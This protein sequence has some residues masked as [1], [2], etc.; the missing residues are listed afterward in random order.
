MRAHIMR[1]FGMDVFQRRSS[2]KDLFARRLCTAACAVIIALCCGVSAAHA[3]DPG[4]DAAPDPP[5]VRVTGSATV[6]GDVYLFS[7]NPDSANRPR[8]PSN[9]WRLILSPTI[10]FGDWLT[11]PL[12]ITLASREVNVTTPV[13]GGS[14][15]IQFLQNPMNNLGFLSISP[16]LGWAQFYLGSHVPQYSE[17]SS[18]DGQVF[19]A[20][21]DLRPGKFRFSA[22]AGSIQRAIEPDSQRGIRGSYARWIYLTK[23]GFGTDESS[24]FDLNFVRARDDPRS[25]TRMPEGLDPQEGVLVT[26]NFKSRFN[27]RLSL[28]GE[29]GTSVFT[30]DMN[31]SGLTNPDAT[32][33]SI[34]RERISSRTDLAGN[35]GI[36]Y[37]QEAW[38][39]KALARYIGA[40]YVALGYPYMQPDRLEYTLSPRA[41]LFENRLA[42]N[43]S[44]GIR[45]NNLSNTKEQTSS[46][47]I[48]SANVLGVITD[49]FNISASYSNFGIRNNKADDTLRIESVSQSIS[50][51][52]TY[53]LPTDAAV[54]TMSVTYSR[55]G[56]N[57]YNVVSGAENSNNT[58]SVMIMYA[59]TFLSLPLSTNLSVNHLTNDLKTGALTI[60]SLSLGGSFRFR[61]GDVVPSLTL[62]WSTSQVEKFT[63]DRQLYLRL[64]SRW[65]INKMFALTLSASRN[66]YWYGSSRPGVSFAETFFQ[67]A[68]TMQF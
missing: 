48:G 11:L 4:K 42:I 66:G 14:N 59:N 63:Q 35:L 12:S 28:T 46:Q 2:S 45:S 61:N 23:I 36:S 26:G 52:P 40:G 31:A 65:K 30:N 47:F 55:D 8:R 32:L 67:T 41:Q 17:L 62:T 57:D 49:D 20:G 51:T 5:A 37:S 15:L 16:K 44:I 33:N 38:G 29:I 21:V 3:Q 50:V 9:L 34:I 43:G 22:S 13:T 19:G 64:S 6:T 27:E 39:V 18:G 25:I 56:Y 53:T 68:M 10:Q 58:Q 54:H 7:S 24:Y 1:K 60:N